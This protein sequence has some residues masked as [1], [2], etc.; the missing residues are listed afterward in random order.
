M[1]FLILALIIMAA[2]VIAAFYMRRRRALKANAGQVENYQCS[3]FDEEEKRDA[4][5]RLMSKDNER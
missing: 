1:L 2:I 5:N 3:L 4:C